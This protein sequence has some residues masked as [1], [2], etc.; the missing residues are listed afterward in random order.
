MINSSWGVLVKDSA[1]ISY[2]LKE[3][4]SPKGY[5]VIVPG[6]GDHID[7]YDHLQRSL[8]GFTCI[9][10]DL[11][12]HGSSSGIRYHIK[13]FD[14][15]VEDI[16]CVVE[17]LTSKFGPVQFSLIGHSQGGLASH[18][19]CLKGKYSSR[20]NGVSLIAPYYDL[21]DSVKPNAFI[22]TAAKIASWVYPQLTLPNSGSSMDKLSDDPW[23]VKVLNLDPV[24]SN[25]LYTVGWFFASKAAQEYIV[26][27][28]QA[29]PSKIPVQFIAAE[30]ENLANNGATKRIY[31][32]MK[33]F[34]NSKTEHLTI[35]G[36]HKL[37]W[38]SDTARVFSEINRFI[39]SL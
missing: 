2:R 3:V 5:V 9:T 10:L 39:G 19:Y 21:N 37:I 22:T 12:G 15:Y 4:E 29:F 24:Y 11:R 1:N 16:D 26:D 33:L 23:W 31:D 13:S 36:M 7:M 38:S 32:E 30:I 14:D 27:K 18:Y 35:K 17:F 20:V 6:Y 25:G 34:K 8:E 28:I